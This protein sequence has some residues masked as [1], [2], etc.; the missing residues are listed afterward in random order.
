[1]WRR[2]VRLLLGGMQTQTSFAV[3]SCLLLVYAPSFFGGFLNWD[4]PWLVVN[5]P[6]L[7]RG[8]GALQT[9]WLDFTPQT[10]FRLGAEYLPFRD[11]SWWL[12]HKLHGLDPHALRL[13]NCLIYVAAVLSFSRFLQRI[14]KNGRV[15]QLSVWLFALHPVHVEIVA[16]ISS[17]KDL[18]ALLAIGIVLS[19]YAKPV[20]RRWLVIG[21]ALCAMFSKSPAVILPGLMLLVD[22]KVERRPNWNLV[23]AVGACAVGAM[24]AHT[25][26]G[27]SVGMFQPPAGGSRLSALINGCAAF[28]SYIGLSFWPWGL[29]LIHDPR[30]I[31]GFTPAALGGLA[32]MA[33][34]TGL[35]WHRHRAGDRTPAFLFGWF[36]IGLLPVLGFVSLQN[37][38]ADRYLALSVLAPCIA[39]ASLLTT[40]G[41]LVPVGLV[42]AAAI[43]SCQRGFVFG[44][45]IR[46]M[47][48][49]TRRSPE[50]RRAAYQYGLA[51]EHAQ[52]GTEATQ[53]YR[54]AMIR[55]VGTDEPVIRSI[56]GLAR[57][58]R[59]SGHLD[60]AIKE[61]ED[62][63]ARFPAEHRIERR[64]EKARSE[65][66]MELLVYP[67]RQQ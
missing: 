55:G 28:W 26:V 41:R 38:L 52:R 11:L 31:H 36:T 20:F 58:L 10:R 44:D 37:L 33:C 54:A 1:M 4:D 14:L 63:A 17:R 51:L 25:A 35:A 43:A 67:A 40:I 9:I 39:V 18:L 2:H 32:V 8:L 45:S 49:S 6:V 24:V 15:A 23:A 60:D 50:S 48:E 21:G 16:W 22:Y 46:V 19:E 12:E 53:A 3:A 59:D 5:N 64:L 13:S 47:G 27:Q 56:E 65:K 61:L 62:G 66:R 29:A 34:A 7:P 42:V 57:I 30:P